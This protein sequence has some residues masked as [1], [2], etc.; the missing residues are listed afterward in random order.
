MMSQLYVQNEAGG[1][2]KLTDPKATGPAKS[3]KKVRKIY[4]LV[5]LNL[6]SD[7][8]GYLLV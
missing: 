5:R 1:S 3:L 7:L 6:H 8:N 2:A 4:S